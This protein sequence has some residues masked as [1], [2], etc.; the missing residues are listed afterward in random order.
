MSPIIIFWCAV[1]FLGCFDGNIKL[2]Y[3]EFSHLFLNL[4]S[5]FF[6]YL[7]F[8]FSYHIRT[9]YFCRHCH[10]F[11][12]FYIL[13]LTPLVFPE[14]CTF[15]RKFLPVNFH[16]SLFF[17]ICIRLGKMFTSQ[18]STICGQWRW[19]RCFKNKMFGPVDID[20]FFLRIRAPQHED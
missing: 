16:F 13:R 1:L 15:S 18:K 19:M 4:Y 20:T 11:D 3:F 5:S 12:F 14:A 7:L 9:L 10:F 6:Y 2:I 17:E 8:T